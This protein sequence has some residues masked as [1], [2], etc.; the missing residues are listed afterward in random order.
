VR[1]AVTGATGFV[2][3]A[4][5]RAAT[6]AG[7]SVV[8]LGRRGGADVRWDITGGPLADPPAVD[9]VVH[10]AGSVSDTAATR[11]Q[12]AANVDGTRNVLASFPA[13]RFVHVST[14][15][16]YDP[17][18]PTVLATEDRAPVARYPDAYG[19]SKAAAE[20]L[21]RTRRPDAVVLR[22]HAVYGPGDT[23]LLPRVLAAVRGGRLV[24]VGDGTQRVSLTAVANLARACLL[25]AASDVAGVFNVA[26]AEPVLLADALAAV[27]A[28]RAIPAR[29]RFVPL[30]VAWPLACVAEAVLRRPRLTRYAV[31]HL[32]HERT[33]DITAART[34]LG[35]RPTPTSFAGAAS[36]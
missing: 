18:R 35:Y 13:A 12:R 25:A 1:L 22:P 26:D 21:V 14:A 15:S 10:C 11:T 5:C 7:W 33:L 2:G 34:V 19:A 30:P 24:A 8:A 4:V 9:A 27:L 3:G 28:E 6:A 32:A 17:L 36:W 16:V 23:T 29:V 20:R 31:R